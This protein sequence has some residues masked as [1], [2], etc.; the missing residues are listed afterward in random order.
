MATR[1][2]WAHLPIPIMFGRELPVLLRHDLYP[3]TLARLP[4]RPVTNDH[5]INKPRGGLWTA[6]AL[7]PKG[8]W[9]PIPRR[10]TWSEWCES[11]MPYMI[12]HGWQT[13][14]FPE[15]DAPFA[16]IDTAADAVALYD[17]FPFDENPVAQ[18]LAEHG[19]TGHIHE[20]MIDWQ[21]LLSTGVAGVYLTDRG[22]IETR[23]PDTSIV[24]SL[25]GWDVATV[26]FGRRAFRV[27]Q[28]WK[29]PPIPADPY[30][31]GWDNE[32]PDVQFNR[33][34]EYVREMAAE[35]RSGESPLTL[36]DYDPPATDARSWDSSPNPLRQLRE[37]FGR[38]YASDGE[39]EM[40]RDNENGSGEEEPPEPNTE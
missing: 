37:E 5:A 38:W 28:T 19:V 11:E 12:N 39:P 14:L 34:M 3:K 26:W 16:V 25:Y 6:P 40:F 24:P 2:P 21:R 7:L 27:G 30:D 10:S 29:C 18:L 22:Q 9:R 13:Q 15:P 8:K 20:K 23:L 4:W 33:S 1:S 35:L 32:P 36:T 17:A 31:M